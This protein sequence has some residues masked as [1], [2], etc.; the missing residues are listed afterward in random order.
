VRADYLPVWGLAGLG[1][2]RLHDALA[3][4]SGS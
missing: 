2:E 1:F 3:R 4:P